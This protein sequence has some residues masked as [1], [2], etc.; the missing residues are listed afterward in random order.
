MPAHR[1][2]SKLA[3]VM[4]RVPQNSSM[5]GMAARYMRK[6]TQAGSPSQEDTGLCQ[7]KH[8]Y[9]RMETMYRYAV[10]TARRVY[11]TRSF[12]LMEYRPN[13]SARL[14]CTSCI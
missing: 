7:K 4:E 8:P 12:F 6:D 2:F 3:A 9:P 11:T 10:C 5:A 14:L 13:T 1:F